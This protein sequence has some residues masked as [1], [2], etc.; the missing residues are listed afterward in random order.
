[1]RICKDFRPVVIMANWTAEKMKE[2]KEITKYCLYYIGENND[3]KFFIHEVRN[4]LL[5]ALSS[6]Y[7]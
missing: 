2:K 6:V 1:M 5:L 3:K 4:K 7:Y